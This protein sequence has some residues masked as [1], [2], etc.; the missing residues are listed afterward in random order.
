LAVILNL[1]LLIRRQDKR[2]ESRSAQLRLFCRSTKASGRN[3]QG[4]EAE[5]GARNTTS[6]GSI[7]WAPHRVT[8]SKKTHSLPSRA[9]WGAVFGAKHQKCAEKRGYN[10]LNV[11]PDSA[12]DR[13]TGLSKKLILEVVPKLQFWNSSL[14]FR[15]KKRALDRFFGSLF[16]NQQGFGTG[17]INQPCVERTGYGWFERALAFN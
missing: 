7:Y 6:N 4:I 3:V 1:E 2:L 16:Q 14:K 10:F 13:L 17:S 15:G 12:Q 5:S 9:F 8:K 11:Y